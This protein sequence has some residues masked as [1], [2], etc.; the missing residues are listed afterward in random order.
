PRNMRGIVNDAM[1]CSARELGISE[2][3][4]G[5]ILLGDDAP[6]GKPFQDYAG[7]VVVE[8]DILPNM[9]RCLSLIGVAREGA[10]L[11][12]QKVR[13]PPHAVEAL[14]EPIEGKARVEIEDPKLCARYTAVLLRNVKLGPSPDWMLWRL[15]FAGVRPISNIVDITNYVMLEWGQ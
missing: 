10:A 14:G 3:H 6:S 15:T 1:V 9:A 2:E 8:I 4:E 5:I 12:G 13:P 11:T 7:D